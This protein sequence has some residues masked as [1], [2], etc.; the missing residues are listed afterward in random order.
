MRIGI[1]LCGSYRRS[2][3]I[4]LKIMLV[5]YLCP[6]YMEQL[7]NH[8]GDCNHQN[9]GYQPG[10]SFRLNILPHNRS[11]NGTW[12]T[13]NFEGSAKIHGCN[14]WSCNIFWLSPRERTGIASAIIEAKAPIV[15]AVF[16]FNMHFGGWR[17]RAIAG[18]FDTLAILA[19]KVL[20]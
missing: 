11:C 20:V 1:L 14:K 10:I 9:N 12:F 18:Q 7:D 17:P 15:T 5:G 16:V 4:P 6:L 19:F 3:L 13:L 2:I 8:E